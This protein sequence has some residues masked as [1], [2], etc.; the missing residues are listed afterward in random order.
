MRKDWTKADISELLE[1][2]IGGVWGSDPGIDEIDVFVY[3]QTEFDDNGTLSMPSDAMRSIT[4]NQLKSRTLQPGDVLMQ[5]SAGTP[6][7]PGRVVIVPDAIE[8]NATCS[9]FLHLLRADTN[10][11]TPQ[12]LFWSLWLNHQSGRAFEFQRGTNIKNLDLNQYLAETV[13][14]PSL[15]EQK[16][17]VDVVS[18][19]DAYIDA[20]QQQADT[21]RTA[22]NAVLHDLLFAGG[23]DW[24]ETTLGEL[25]EIYQPETIS[26]AQMDDAAQYIVYGAN[27]PVG[28]FSRFNHSE[29]EVVVTCRGA[30]CGVVNMT[31]ANC[32]I[33]GNAMVVK[34]RDDRSTK[35]FLFWALQTSVDVQAT[36]SG[37]AQPQ[38]TR[39][40]LT[41]SK[42]QVPPISE[43]K[44]IV[45]I[46]S[47][48]DEVIQSTEK[49]VIDAKALRSGLLS[50]LLSGNHEIPASYDSLLGAS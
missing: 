15:A 32:W 11:C 4:K 42:I 21:A 13:L 47:A 29:P 27:G 8:S 38:I 10:K 23:D 36:I 18:S 39:A 35:G 46:V 7:L 9:N 5:K 19:A 33:T 34:P 3:R 20:L 31:P 14:L 30:T 26:K 48:M 45:E 17:I 1:V 25:C 50:D 24:T 28:R 43:Q 40:G 12:F 44:Q 16:R 49:A 22:R 6:T 37:S 41:P 2:S